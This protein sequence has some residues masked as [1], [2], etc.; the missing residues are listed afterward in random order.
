MRKSRAKLTNLRSLNFMPLLS[1][2]IPAYNER[3]TISAALERVL[4]VSLPGWNKE[5]IVVDDGS[6]DGMT[7]ILQNFRHPE[8]KIFFSS[9]NQGKG[10]SLR[11]GFQKASGDVIIVQDA[12]LEYNPQDYAA[13]IKPLAENQAE[14]VYG[15]RFVGNQPHR[16]FYNTHYLANRFLTFLSNLFT[17]LNLS[18]METGYKVFSQKALREILPCLRA[19]RFGIEPELTAQIAKHHFRVYEVGISY[20]GRTYQE[21]KKI[22]WK[23]GLA[24]VWHVI[25]SNL[26]TRK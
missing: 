13:L 6:T 8:V 26:F 7:E 1:I 25:R 5:I 2:V 12:D 24:A 4:A 19:Q 20:S 22:N 3:S 11:Q 16:V 10:A 9:G 21:G 14:V 18:D 23:D 15:S 17:G